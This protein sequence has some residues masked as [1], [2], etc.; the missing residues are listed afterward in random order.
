LRIPDDVTVGTYVV[1]FVVFGT[2]FMAR[3]GEVARRAAREWIDVAVICEFDV[4][5][6]GGYG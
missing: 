4:H 2:S 5:M 3:V 1:C 6:W